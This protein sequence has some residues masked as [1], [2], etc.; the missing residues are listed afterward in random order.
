KGE[1]KVNIRKNAPKAEPAPAAKA[2][3]AKKDAPIVITI[4]G[5]SYNVSLE[6][7]KVKVNGKTYNYDISD[8]KAQETKAAPAATPSASQPVAGT[9]L[10][11]PLPGLILRIP[12]NVG[13]KVSA[14][15][16][17]LVLEAMKME[18]EIKAPASGTIASINVKQGDQ[19]TT[20]TVLACI[21]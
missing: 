16:T 19:V 21:Q 14:G 18:T 7:G 15:D 20:D 8:A 9:V 12:A 17:V 10:K 4:D 1:A 13:D 2:P 5:E 6:D 3:E 11:A